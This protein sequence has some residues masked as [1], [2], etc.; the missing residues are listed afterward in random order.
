VF[1]E[2]NMKQVDCKDCTACCSW[3]DDISLRVSLT[4]VDLA[5]GINGVA[6]P[7]G[8]VL[9]VTDGL[10]NCGYLDK[11]ARKCKIHDHKPQQC[12]KFDCRDLLAETA[13]G[14]Y[15]LTNVLVSA[16]YLNKDS[17]IQGAMMRVVGWM[18]ADACTS[19]D[20]GEDYRKVIMPDLIKRLRKEL[21]I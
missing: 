10:G 11:K 8:R 3:G 18:Y 14:N 15:Y 20:R 12:D 9:I 1:K 19:L 4:P 2:N 7:S 16:I 17:I 21:N 6:D 13:S 5:K